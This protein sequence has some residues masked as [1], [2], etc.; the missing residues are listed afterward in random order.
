MGTVAAPAASAETITADVT[1]RKDRL[2]VQPHFCRIRA[3]MKHRHSVT[4]V[5]L[6]WDLHVWCIAERDEFAPDA[7]FRR[8]SRTWSRAAWNA[9][10]AASAPGDRPSTGSTSTIVPAP[11][12]TS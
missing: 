11:R 10:I 3:G 5:D 1:G 2:L 7:Q 8:W 4:Y 6:A 9:P 12:R